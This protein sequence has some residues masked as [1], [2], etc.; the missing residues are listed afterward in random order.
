EY[1]IKNNNLA[2]SWAKLTAFINAQF[3]NSNFIGFL[4]TA[5][6]KLAKMTEVTHPLTKAM[7][8]EVAQVNLLT[9]ELTSA[10]TPAERRNKIYEELKRIAPDVVANID[11]ENISLSTLKGNLEKYNTEMIK[12][13]ALQDS[14]ESL[15][16]KREAA[17]KA[18]ND[19]IESEIKLR[20]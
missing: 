13:L 16:D 6:G 11:A 15:A 7:K 9:I 2:G 18:T 4:E 14:E 19:R 1:A 3:I 8:N 17:G 10:N 5:I 12:K 20:E